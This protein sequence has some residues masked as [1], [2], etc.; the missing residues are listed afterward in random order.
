M[1]LS[2]AGKTVL[3]E[4]MEAWFAGNITDEE[5]LISAKAVGKIERESFL[6]EQG[7]SQEGA[8]NHVEGKDKGVDV[9]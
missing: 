8:K 9:L 3:A 4:R 2:N 6:Q 5:F 1:T 7:F